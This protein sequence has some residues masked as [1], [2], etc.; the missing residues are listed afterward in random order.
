[1]EFFRDLTADTL[2]DLHAIVERDAANRHKWNNVRC[3]DP[4][5]PAFMFREIDVAEGLFDAPNRSRANGLGRSNN[6]NHRA[7]MIGVHLPA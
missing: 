5:V 1:M 7:I 2:C 4:R 3:A 6:G